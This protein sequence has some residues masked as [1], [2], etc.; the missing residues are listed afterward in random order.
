MIGCINYKLFSLAAALSLFNYTNQ[1]N[2]SVRF[3]HHQIDEKYKLAVSCEMS[4]YEG[5]TL[6]LPAPVVPHSAGRKPIN[7]QNLA[8]GIL[9]VCDH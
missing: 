6:S 5:V 8:S 7:F 2:E 3:F 1:S 4:A 9:A